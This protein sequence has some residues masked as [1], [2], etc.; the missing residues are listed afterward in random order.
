MA[1][2]VKASGTQAV[3]FCKTRVRASSGPLINFIKWVFKYYLD[4]ILYNCV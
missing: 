2:L 4:V 1:Q 3:Y